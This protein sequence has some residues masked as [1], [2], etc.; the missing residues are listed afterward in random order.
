MYLRETLF[1]LEKIVETS[2]E[3]SVNSSL[4]PN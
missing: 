3:P 4:L 1:H 2:E